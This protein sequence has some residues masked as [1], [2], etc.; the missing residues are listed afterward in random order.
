MKLQNKA[1][2]AFQHSYMDEKSVLQIIEIQAGEIKDIPEEVA[3]VWLKS[4]EV[5]EFVEPKEAKALEDENAKLK[6][7]LAKLKKPAVTK[8]PATKK[9]V[10]KKTVKK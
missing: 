7:E 1:R 6:A 5:V 8:K 4:G 2:H 9:P 10:T 3:K